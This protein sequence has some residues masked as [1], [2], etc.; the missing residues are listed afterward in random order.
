MSKW[1]SKATNV[2]KGS[3]PESPA[4]FE[5]LCECGVR[6]AGMRKKIPQRIV[7]RE[8]GTSLFVLPRDVY[9]PPK[10][11]ATAD[12]PPK[13]DSPASPPVQT[14][15]AR[16]AG[17]EE[18]ELAPVDSVLDEVVVLDDE[19]TRAPRKPRPVKKVEPPPQK[20]KA[21]PKPPERLVRPY[22]FVLAAVVGVVSLTIYFAVKSRARER[23]LLIY[24]DEAE[25]GLAAVAAHS[26][27]EARGHLDLAADAADLLRRDDP[28]SR[29]VRQ[30]RSETTAINQL[31]PASLVDILE[32]AERTLP[33]NY[34][35]WYSEFQSKYQGRWLILE[36]PVKRL[37]AEGKNKSGR[38]V[39]DW[40]IPLGDSHRPVE[41]VPLPV[42]DKLE[43]SE[44][45]QNVI[46][47]VEL[48]SV[49]W[50]TANRRDT[51]GKWVV[52]FNPRTSV[53]WTDLGTYEGAGVAFSEEY[54][55]SSATEQAL[56]EQRKALGLEDPAPPAT[57]VPPAGTEP[58]TDP[59]GVKEA[60]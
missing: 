17:D 59:A 10:V 15:S 34:S 22:H 52:T 46:L 47:G 38:I 9:P 20:K 56:L 54:R 29:R 37:A 21:P 30:Y 16:S 33:D 18:P 39:L 11:V 41:I 24:N 57:E 60:T 55:P 50:V 43:L 25:S 32:E 51:E 31:A 1:F 23:A 27:I 12:S 3:Q 14:P 44:T 26:W 28:Q 45:P 4:P 58:A 53:L 35:S 49:N 8:C 6:H 19:G 2:F 42:L 40:S 13:S 36:L 5:L 7:C 48:E